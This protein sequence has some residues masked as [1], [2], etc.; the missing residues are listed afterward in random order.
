MA[1]PLDDRMCLRCK[2]RK[3]AVA[4]ATGRARRCEQCNDEIVAAKQQRAS[5]RAE[6]AVTKLVDGQWVRR[7]GACRETKNLKDGFYRTR[8]TP[9][10]KVTLDFEY[11][12]KACQCERTSALQRHM[13][14][15]DPTFR[16][17]R[18]AQRSR[19][20]KNNPDKYR[21]A[22]RRQRERIKADP[23][24]HA[25]Y[26][27]NQR[28]NYRLRKERAGVPLDQI[29]P[30]QVLVQARERGGMLPTGPLARAIDQFAARNDVTEKNAP[31]TVGA[32]LRQINAW[33][34]GTYAEVQMV[35]ASRVLD[36]ID[37]FW[38]EVWSPEDPEAHG[39]AYTVFEGDDEQIAA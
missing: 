16:D 21:E 24:R 31:S 34:D 14:K 29:K 26:R 33:R 9:T 27:E 3:P 28:I 15:I 32:H 6:R 4:Y 20:R 2:I 18:T 36:H 30:A 23:K 12:C 25:E 17:K 19:W 35:V 7:C 10:G 5:E 39:R 13:R 8:S 37:M 11:R 38:W 1:R 22:R